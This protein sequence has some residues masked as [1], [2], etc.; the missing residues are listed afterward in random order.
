[1]KIKE[2]ELGDA[3]NKQ[4]VAL[5]YDKTRCKTIRLKYSFEELEKLIAAE[6]KEV[7]ANDGAKQ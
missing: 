1:M 3:Q 6:V 2:I 4:D 7:K 5:L